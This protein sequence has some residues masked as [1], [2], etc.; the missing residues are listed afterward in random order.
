MNKRIG[1]ILG[2]LLLAGSFGLTSPAYSQATQAVADAAACPGS[3]FN[4]VTDPNWMYVFPITIMGA[5]IGP[6]SNPPGMYEPPICN[7]WSSFFGIP[8]P[9]LGVT[10]WAPEYIAEVEKNPGCFS[11]LGGIKL[12]EGYSMLGSE[13]AGGEHAGS[14]ASQASR[15]QIHW[16]TYPLY[17]MLKSFTSILCK[18]TNTVVDLAYVTEIDPVW[19]S[20][21]WSAILGPEAGLFSNVIAQTACALDAT[22]AGVYFPIG[23]LFWCAGSAGA[24]YPL[25]GTAGHH[26]SDQSSNM[27]VLAKFMARHHRIG[28]LWGSIGPENICNNIPAPVWIKN[29]YRI[30]PIW[31]SPNYSAPIY[32]G[33]T[34]FRWGLAPPANYPTRES[35]YNLIWVGKQCCIRF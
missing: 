35:A 3:M 26:Q 31:P 30:N 28:I 21:I 16:Y 12:L 6:Y 25:S 32:F 10:Y 9:G 19:Q 5:P 27:L 29:Q 22:A 11:S 20:D 24:V 13:K 15:M 1:T 7:C 2:G 4:P 33:Q 17:G 23:T 18:N 34:E 8:L 14:S